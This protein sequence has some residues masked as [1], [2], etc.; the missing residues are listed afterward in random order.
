M[1]EE[2]RE[3]VNRTVDYLQ[4]NKEKIDSVFCAT[5]KKNSIKIEMNIRAGDLANILYELAKD[6][7]TI[8]ESIKLAQFAIEKYIKH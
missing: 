8:C 5:I 6:D 3:T 4:E 1:K 2:V 7:E